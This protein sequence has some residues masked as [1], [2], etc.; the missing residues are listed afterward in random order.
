MNA[1]AAASRRDE[2]GDGMTDEEKREIIRSA[3]AN[4]D[5]PRIPIDEVDRIERRERERA[6]RR[7]RIDCETERV[8]DW[9]Q[10]KNQEGDAAATPTETWVA[11]IE[12]RLQQERDLMVEAVGQALG[13][14]FQQMAKEINTEQEAKASKLWETLSEIQYNLRSLNRIEAAQ[15]R[16]DELALARRDVH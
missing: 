8:Y 12:Q 15:K 10:R 11:W 6:A 2:R 13:E 5:G 3:R 1:L 9:I 14:A 16:D 4:A 7:Q